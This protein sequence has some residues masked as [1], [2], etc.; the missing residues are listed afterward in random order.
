MK[1]ILIMDCYWLLMSYLIIYVAEKNRSYTLILDF[2]GKLVRFAVIRNLD[3][4][5]VFKKCYLTIQSSNLLPNS[6]AGLE[7]DLN[8][9]VSLGKILHMTYHNDF[10]K[11]MI[12]IMHTLESI[13]RNSLVCTTASVKNWMITSIYSQYIHHICRHLRK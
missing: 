13:C 1:C 6:S 4:L 8:K 5:L 10:S 11:K 9:Y 2:Y 3:L 12:T 7:N